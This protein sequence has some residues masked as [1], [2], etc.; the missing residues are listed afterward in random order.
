[1]LALIFVVHVAPDGEELVLGL[2]PL[3]VG[4]NAGE[5]VRA[6][7]GDGMADHAE[8]RLVGGL[9]LVVDAADELLHVAR[10]DVLDLGSDIRVAEGFVDAGV[11]SA[12]YVGVV[13]IVTMVR[14]VGGVAGESL[15][16]HVVGGLAMPVGEV[17]KLAVPVLVGDGGGPRARRVSSPA[18]GAGCVAAWR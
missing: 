15:V 14:V 17:E 6:L 16:H 13:T 11:S 10:P 12:L 18:C 7:D 8:A 5:V 2:E 4:D 3:G 9:V 1:M